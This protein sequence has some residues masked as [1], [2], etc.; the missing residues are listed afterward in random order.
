MPSQNADG[1]V[2]DINVNSVKVRNW[3]N[4]VTM[5]P[6]LSMVSQSF[7]NWRGMENSKGRRFVRSV[8][9]DIKSVFLLDDKLL[10]DLK[11][12]RGCRLPMRKQKAAAL[13]LLPI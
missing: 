9:I 1:T 6:I 10:Y 5:V 12:I 13:R 4:T 3:N 7:V 2:L 11:T 8:N